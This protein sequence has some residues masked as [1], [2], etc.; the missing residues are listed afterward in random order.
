M[1]L[2]YNALWILLTNT[3]WSINRNKSPSVLW[4]FPS[5][6]NVPTPAATARIFVLLLRYDVP[7]GFTAR[8]LDDS[9]HML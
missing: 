3:M 2:S 6:F 9:F 7:N 8:A 1:F 4:M 5:F